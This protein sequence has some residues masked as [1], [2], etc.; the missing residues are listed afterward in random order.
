VPPDKFIR[1][2]ENS[3]LIV[4]IGE[5]VLRTACSQAR[6]WQDEG[7]PAVPVAVNVSAVQFRQEGFC[8]LVRRVLH[9]TGLAPNILNWNLQKASFYPMQ[10]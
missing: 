6:K 7:I 2:A 3:G 5:W 8:E 1:I 4:P 10:T 9:E